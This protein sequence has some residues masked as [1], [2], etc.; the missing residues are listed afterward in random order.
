MKPTR[1]Y[2]GVAALGVFLSATAVWLREPLFLLGAAA[3]FG[4]L[5]GEQ[6]RFG[7]RVRRLAST[8]TVDQMLDRETL[9]SNDPAFL[10]LRV[11]L[12]ADGPSSFSLAA[13][14]GVG[15]A[16]TRDS[17]ETTLTLAP[18]EIEAEVTVDRSWPV[19]GTYRLDQPTVTV[20][21]R[22]GLFQSS[23]SAGPRP[24]V[25]VHGRAGAGDDAGSGTEA[26]SRF[27]DELDVRGLRGGVEPIEV[28]QFVAGDTMSRIDWKA[29]ARRND[30]HVRETGSDAAAATVVVLDARRSMHQGPPD[31]TKLDYGRSLALGVARLVQQ[32][33]RPLGLIVVDD[34]GIDTRLEPRATPGQYARIVRTL[35]A[36]STRPGTV[37]GGGASSPLRARHRLS[38][39]DARRTAA[40]L[41]GGS[42]F[43][44]A[45]RPF[46][47]DG[48]VR[49]TD[50]PLSRALREAGRGGVA[51][52]TIL[53]TDDSDPSAVREAAADAGVEDELVVIFLPTVLFTLD[54]V[55]ATGRAY[56]RLAD[57]RSLS[58]RLQRLDGVSVYEAGPGDR[59]ETIVTEGRQD[60]ERNG[61]R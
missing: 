18:G 21:D 23:F 37:G 58:R 8:V 46:F 54:S 50:R 13:T 2:W 31:R 1:R 33:N 4:W 14:P 51:A 20:S 42:T 56:D 49:T 12:P 29:T 47:A 53:L 6:L 30:L 38:A 26:L 16:A 41:D 28:R 25:T 11:A 61:E 9:A 44:T 10:T 60:R 43:D 59:L 5:V 45:L 32:A 36:V 27:G 55:E 19:G 48:Q 17:P 35:E 3:T 52:Q 22:A 39:A 34:D 7:R 15:A 40:R 57:F 24:T